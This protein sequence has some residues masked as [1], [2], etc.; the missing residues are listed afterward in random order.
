MRLAR[1]CNKNRTSLSE[2]SMKLISLESRDDNVIAFKMLNSR[3]QSGQP[4]VKLL[5]VVFA[6]EPWYAV[7]AQRRSGRKDFFSAGVDRW[8]PRQFMIRSSLG[9]SFVAG[10]SL[11]QQI[12]SSSGTHRLMQYAYYIRQQHFSYIIHFFFYIRTRKKNLPL[13][14]LKICQN[15]G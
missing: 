6:W 14:V 9:W 2:V 13:D 10:L 11:E 1:K 4:Y 8:D 15:W 12:L 7:C 3:S 5:L